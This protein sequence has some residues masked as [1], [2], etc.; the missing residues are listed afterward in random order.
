MSDP[1]I[2]VENVSKRYAPLSYRPKL[3]HEAVQMVKSWLGMKSHA[4]WRG[5]P[6]WALKNVSFTVRRGEAVGIIGRNG[7]GKTTLL[8]LLSGIMDPSEGRVQVSGRFATLIGLGAGFDGQRTGRENIYLNAAIF[9]FP[10]RQVDA[11]IDDIVAFSELGEFLDRPVKNYS[12]GMVARLGFSI[13]VHIFPDIIFLD[14]ILSVG[15]LA[16]QQ[17]CM[18]KMLQF[19]EQ[20]CT[21][22]FV[23]H[24][25]GAVQM[26]CE[27]S[28][29]LHHGEL[30]LDGPTHEVTR[31]YEQMLGMF[32]APQPAG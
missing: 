32:E 29:W 31:S 8:R 19:K 21:F 25:P 15:D 3:R 13:A 28:L 7:A 17:K 10:P 18:D 26:L 2:V 5:E 14:E 9:G 11:F 22:M 12:S 4:S 6:F 24:D 30:M 1:I 23:S 27:R 16:F 20:G